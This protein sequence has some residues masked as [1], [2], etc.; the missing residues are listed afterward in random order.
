MRRL[1]VVIKWAIQATVVLSL[2]VF[3]VRVPGKKLK[4]I[5]ILRRL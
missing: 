2:D 5:L 4:I 1:V 3:S